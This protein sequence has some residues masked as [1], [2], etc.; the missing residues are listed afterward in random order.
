MVLAVSAV[1][2][3]NQDTSN[4]D[5][6][7]R[8]AQVLPPHDIQLNKPD[9][10]VRSISIP[11]L[12]QQPFEIDLRL[13][14]R[15]TP[16]P[17][18]A[19]PLEDNFPVQALSVAPQTN[20]NLPEENLPTIAAEPPLNPDPQDGPDRS[21]CQEIKG[22]QYRSDNERLWYF[23]YCVNIKYPGYDPDKADQMWDNVAE[24]EAHGN[25]HLDTGNGFYGGLQFDQTTWESAGGAG[26][27]AQ[28]SREEQ[29][30]RAE[31]TLA[32]QGWGAWP[33]CSQ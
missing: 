20:P 1:Y 31:V 23:R 33:N 12:A 19:S 3:E 13:L 10:I 16:V 17:E 32:N 22:T 15:E 18:K 26:N 5:Q 4:Q 27:P 6:T 25:W 9:L 24:C 29:I 14:A 8:T 2:T 11:Q 30:L 7:T 21:N 28:A